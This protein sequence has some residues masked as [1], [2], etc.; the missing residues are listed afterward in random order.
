MQIRDAKSPADISVVQGLWREYWESF[1]LAPEF[2]GF[3]EELRGLPGVYGS[4]GG[5]LLLA[6]SGDDPVGTIALRRLNATSGEVKRLYIRPQFRGQGLARSLLETV[7]ERASALGYKALYAD[8]LPVMTGALNLY[9]R[10]GFES[11]EAYSD[12]PTPGAIFM[13]LKLL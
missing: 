4:H 2:Q 13:K 8:T 9:K 11:A 7:I 5:A 3:D 12:T 1:S 6:F 10:L